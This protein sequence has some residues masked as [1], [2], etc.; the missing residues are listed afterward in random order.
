MSQWHITFCGQFVLRIM[1]FRWSW[2]VFTTEILLFLP[3]YFVNLPVCNTP[4]AYVYLDI[5]TR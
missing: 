5:A 2:L 3:Y 1:K 4:I